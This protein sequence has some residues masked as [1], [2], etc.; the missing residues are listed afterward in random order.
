MLKSIQITSDAYD[1]LERARRSDE[2]VSD[3]ISRL[4]NPPRSAED[5]LRML[6]SAGLSDE[7]LD[8][9]DES[10]ERRRSIPRRPNA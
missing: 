6:R 5:V 9:I 3:V 8:A 4:V 1:R 7:T 2:T 10:V